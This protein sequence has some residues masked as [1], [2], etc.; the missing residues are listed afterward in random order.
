MGGGEQFFKLVD[1]L[2]R[3]ASA[4]QV[5]AHAGRDG[6]K[7]V[8]GL[9]GRIGLAQSPDCRGH[10]LLFRTWNRVDYQI[11]NDWRL[12]RVEKFSERNQ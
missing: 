1:D 11:L 3:G 4:Q 9:N 5:T 6:I 12:L 7:Q 2:S 10:P 8:P